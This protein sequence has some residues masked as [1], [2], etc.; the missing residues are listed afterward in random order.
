[1]N[2]EDTKR[3]TKD[4]DGLLTYE[5]IANHIGEDD[6]DIEFLTDNMIKADQNGQFT[7]SAARYLAAIDATAFA[8]QISRLVAAAIDKDRERRYIGDLLPSLWGEDYLSHADELSHADD[9]FRRIY[10]RIHA[11][12][13]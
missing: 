12:G 13:I 11:T 4:T 8:P 9:N 7:V 2:E 10:K 5:Y 1:M 3:L 6:L